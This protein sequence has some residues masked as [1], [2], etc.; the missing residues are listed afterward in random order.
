MLVAAHND[1]LL[2]AAALGFRTAFVA[3]P[4]EYGPHQNKDFVADDGIDIA[5][6]DLIELAEVL[7][8]G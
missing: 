8:D 1:D 4:A 3:R 6:A 2:A 7:A 5:V